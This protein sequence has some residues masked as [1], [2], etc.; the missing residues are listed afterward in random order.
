MLKV[1][2]N[3]KVKVFKRASVSLTLTSIGF[4]CMF[5][6]VSLDLVSA[7]NN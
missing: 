4:V 3:Q 6:C 2:I 5:V 7:E 1:V